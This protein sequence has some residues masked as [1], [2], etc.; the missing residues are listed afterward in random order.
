MGLRSHPWVIPVLILIIVMLFGSSKLPDLAR[1]MG[2]A[3][4]IVKKEVKDLREDDS[5]APTT[6]APQAP[7]AQAPAA[8]Q[9]PA[10]PQ[11]PAAPPAAP[12]APADATPAAPQQPADP[13]R[14]SDG[15]AGDSPTK[16]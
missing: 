12:Q 1:N 10:A 15:D 14:A 4:K 13:A 5:Q 7:A 9:Q 6:T 8:P 2:R 3:L 16:D 11:A